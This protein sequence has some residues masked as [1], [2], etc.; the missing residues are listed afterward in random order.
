MDERQTA[1]TG[2]GVNGGFAISPRSNRAHSDPH[3]PRRG[4][5]TR[6]RPGDGST[7]LSARDGYDAQIACPVQTATMSGN[8]GS[9]A[10]ST[11]MS[12]AI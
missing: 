1:L 3:L 7:F 11:T 8:A 2:V 12:L 5:V 10:T 6:S 4:T 9:A